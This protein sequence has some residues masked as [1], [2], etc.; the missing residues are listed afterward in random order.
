MKSISVLFVSLILIGGTAE[1]GFSQNVLVYGKHVDQEKSPDRNLL[2][3]NGVLRL[4]ADSD[5][6][7]GKITKIDPGNLSIEVERPSGIRRSYRID[8]G[9]RSERLQKT[10][11]ELKKGDMIRFKSAIRGP[12]EVITEIEKIESSKI[13]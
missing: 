4:I 8:H 13:E 5:T 3:P 6:T 9:I 7:I 11:K 2:N 12:A 1:S 10:V